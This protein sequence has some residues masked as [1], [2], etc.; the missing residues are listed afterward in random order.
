MISTPKQGYFAIKSGIWVL[1][2]HLPNFPM[3][4]DNQLLVPELD[5]KSQQYLSQQTTK[6]FGDWHDRTLKLFQSHRDANTYRLRKPSPI[7]LYKLRKKKSN[8]FGQKSIYVRKCS[9]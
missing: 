8:S 1:F 2:L 5:C 7:V 4:F 9:F 3:A 6:T